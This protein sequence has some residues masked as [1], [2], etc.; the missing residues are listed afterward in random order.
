M[1]PICFIDY[2][3]LTSQVGSRALRRDPYPCFVLGV[4]AGA[5]WIFAFAQ[6]FPEQHRLAV[7]ALHVHPIVAATDLH[8]QE[9]NGSILPRY[10]FP[11]SL[12]E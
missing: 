4:G 3:L 5:I 12:L 11:I 9:G 6:R 8:H 10:A 7:T 1:R 2:S